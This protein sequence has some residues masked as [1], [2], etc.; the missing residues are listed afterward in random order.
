[1]YQYLLLGNRNEMAIVLIFISV[2]LC[3]RGRFWLVVSFSALCIP[4]LLYVGLAR[5]GGLEGSAFEY[6]NPVT[7]YLNTLGEFVFPHYPLLDHI[8]SRQDLWYGWSYLRFPATIFPTF[9]LWGKQISLALQFAEDTGGVGGMGYAYTPLGEGYA[10]FGVA[11]VI[12][13]PLYI[14]ICG[15]ICISRK[16][17]APLFFLV[18]LS[19]SLNINRGEFV[20]IAQEMIILVT[21][22]YGF[23]AISRVHYRINQYS[24]TKKG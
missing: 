21:M 18:F 15:R 7:F 14:T 4:A 3:L 1:M 17:G 11:S 10:N 22:L 24:V 9:G 8:S 16:Y 20:S 12:V 2:L 13:V 6:S 19:L 5:G 23:L